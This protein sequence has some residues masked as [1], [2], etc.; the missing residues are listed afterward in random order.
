MDYRLT[1]S[2]ADPPGK[3]ES[4][5]SEKL[6]RLPVCD[7]C[8]SE[9]DDAPPGGTIALGIG[10]INPLRNIEQFRQGI[11]RHHGI[12]GRDFN[13]NAFIRLIIKSQGLGEKSL[14]P[15]IH[16]R[17]ASRGIPADRLEIRGHE[18][19]VTS[20]LEATTRWIALNTFP[21]HGTTTTCEALWM[22][23]PVVSLAGLTHSSRV[24]V[25]LLSTVGLPELIAQS[26]G[27]IC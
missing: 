14:R 1:D 27:R 7:W 19:N 8:F 12:V 11:F 10:R 4:F 26:A 22:G 24:G 16:Q 23:V 25:S 21:Y 20:H 3:T 6:L 18:P 13:R 2:L 9:P 5:H 15:P 17:F